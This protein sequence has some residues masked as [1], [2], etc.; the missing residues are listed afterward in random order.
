MTMLS[1]TYRTCTHFCAM[2]VSEGTAT[3]GAD[4]RTTALAGAAA[5]T[6]AGAAWRY[7]VWPFTS[8]VWAAIKA[9]PQIAEDVRD[10]PQLISDLRHLLEAN[11]VQEIA[12]LKAEVASLRAEVSVLRGP[13]IAGGE[14]EA[15]GE[16][17]ML[18]PDDIA[19]VRERLQ[20]GSHIPDRGGE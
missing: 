10:L 6:V 5:V 15:Q 12:N 18:S 11:V 4:W 17:F 16:P 3:M 20:R 8:A 9:A 2:N 7:L 14:G 19:S 13:V 1:V